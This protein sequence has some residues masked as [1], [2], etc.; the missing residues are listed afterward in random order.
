M[1]VKAGYG[2]LRRIARLL[3]LYARMDLLLLTRD[4]LMTA[5]WAITDLV[6]NLASVSGLLLLAQRFAGIGTWSRPSFV[7]MLGYASL[8]EGLVATLFG[9]NVSHISRRIGRG[10]LDH[11][12]LQPQPL[13]IVLLTEGFSP[14][15]GAP[16]LLPGTLLLIWG[17]RM[18]PQAPWAA[19]RSM[20]HGC[21]ALAWSGLFVLDMAS[22]VVV[23]MAFQYGWGSLAFWSPRASEELN[24]ST[25]DLLSTLKSFPLNAMSP[26]LRFGLLSI[27][28][29]G[30]VGWAPVAGLLQIGHIWFL[31]TP[32]AALISAAAAA[33]VF[34]AG[35]K[36][37]GKTGSQRYSAFGHRS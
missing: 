31:I 6:I 30:F 15:F 19:F 5:G 26:I 4:P 35:L 11:S 16:A 22:S 25:H 33:I 2:L 32:A 36:H 1:A 24:T 9:Y 20:G 3:A 29:A 34:K 10:Q 14:A 18:L 17:W 21:G 12:L 23:V 27:I 7:F 8:V 37:Y 28:P 13:W